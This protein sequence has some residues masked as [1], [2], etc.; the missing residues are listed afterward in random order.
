M[1]TTAGRLT[2]DSPRR[3]HVLLLYDEPSTPARYYEGLCDAGFEVLLE[4]DLER[5]IVTATI[6]LPDVIVV[7]VH[8]HHQGWT[9]FLERVFCNARTESIPL[10]L[11]S[12]SVDR[13]THHPRSR[14]LSLYPR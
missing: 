8:S 10:L 12:D 11:V 13:I 4:T 7:D 5:A 6:E 3:H 1:M 14:N 9:Q 2:S